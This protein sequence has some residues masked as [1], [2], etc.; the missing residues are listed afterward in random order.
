MSL[1]QP[2]PNT[3]IAYTDWNTVIDAIEARLGTGAVVDLLMADTT[4]IKTG[5]VDGDYFLIKVVDNDTNALV[6]IARVLGAA[7]PVIS[8][9]SSQEFKWYASGIS[10]KAAGAA[11][12]GSGVATFAVSDDFMV[13]TGDSG[14]NTVTTITGGVTGQEL[15]LLFVDTK[16]TITDTD[17]HTAN[18]VDLSASFTSADDVILKLIFNGTSWYEISRSVN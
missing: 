15:I 14:G 17:A 3:E 13:I 12:L 10:G 11:T 5:I 2:Y 9:G 18:T 16:V 8:F 7:D 1:P 4:S 6:E